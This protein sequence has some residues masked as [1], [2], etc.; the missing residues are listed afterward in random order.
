MIIIGNGS[1]SMQLGV[2]QDNTRTSNSRGSDPDPDTYLK[3]SPDSGPYFKKGR[4]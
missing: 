4:I 2:Q 1:C 3:K